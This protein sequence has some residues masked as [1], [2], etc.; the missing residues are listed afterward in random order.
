MSSPLLARLAEVVDG[1]TADIDVP[2]LLERISDSTYD[3]LSAY[4]T[5]VVVRDGDSLHIMAG[6]GP[7]QELVGGSFPFEG[8]AVE[9]LLDSGRR[10]LVA[11]G[12]QYPHLDEALFEGDPMG[13]A[14]ALTRTDG[15]GALYVLRE[16]PL[17]PEE[18]QVL[19]LLAASA[20][21][22]L[23]SAEVYARV[24]LERR[25]K[26]AVIDA[27][28]DGLAVLDERG[29]VRTWNRALAAITGV[30]AE[31]AVGRPLPF[32]L[33]PVG[34]PLDHELRDSRWIEVIAAP[35][36]GT[37]DL[38]VDVRD[39]SR[40]KALE[41]AKDLFLAT[42]S[43]ELRTPLTVLRG[44]GETLLNHWDVLTDERR[45]D[46]VQTILTR[47]QAMTGLVEQLLLGSR[48][49]IGVDVHVQPFDL[50]AAVRGSVSMM[51]G[52]R[53]DH[54][55]VVDASEPV[56][57]A[58]D[59]TTVDAVLGQLVEN[60]VKYSPGGGPID[61][62]VGVEDGE[63]VLRVADTGIGIPAE[64]LARVFDRFVRS[65]SRSAHAPGGAGLGL[66]IV[67]RYLEAQGGRVAAQRRR[68]GGTVIVVRLPLAGG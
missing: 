13:L 67:R 12:G 50:A 63:A 33:P 38:V 22:A 48:A 24:D 21:A 26:E 31:Q 60:A 66:W 40:V 10:S 16:Q 37:P 9:A 6:S 15:R 1:L 61:I 11:A 25:E 51:A 3:L 64:D 65:D 56:I 14:V 2:A 45:R 4:V 34:E 23:R 41:N 49:G 62:T 30:P 17:T 19:E 47:T 44:F 29:L 18:M 52:S 57:V 32:P 36:H 59:K 42:A 27:M 43:H 39:V 54:P 5:G 68:G 46:I 7:R 35:V 8:S 58:G 20:G 55:L 53:P 28:A